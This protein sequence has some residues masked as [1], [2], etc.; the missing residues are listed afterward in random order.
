[1]NLAPKVYSEIGRIR[2]GKEKE[3]TQWGFITEIAQMLGCGG[4]DCSCGECDDLYEEMYPS[5]RRLRKKLDNIG[6]DFGD[7]H[8]GNI[9]YVRRRGRNVLVCIDTGEESVY[10]DEYARDYSDYESDCSCEY[11]QNHR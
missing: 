9:G 8:I 4:N 1:Y 7:D 10:D 2:I 5:V 11:C 6:V 3:L